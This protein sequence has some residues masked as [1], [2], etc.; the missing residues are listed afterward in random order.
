[1]AY[2]PVVAENASKSVGLG[3]D[4]DEI[5]AID[6]V[7]CAFDVKLDHTDARSWFTVGDVF[8]SVQKA[9]PAEEISSAVGRIDRRGLL[10][11]ASRFGSPGVIAPKSKVGTSSSAPF[12]SK[13]RSRTARSASGPSD[14]RLRLGEAEPGW[15]WPNQLSHHH[16]EKP[17]PD[18]RYDH[19]RIGGKQT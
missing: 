4:G 8:R 13:A 3:G 12:V 5:A 2:P 14:S 6:E 9:P 19:E 10:S 11:I 7:E 15:F 16:P 1:M 17:R 18:G